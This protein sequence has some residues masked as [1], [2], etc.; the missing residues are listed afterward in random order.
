M[1]FLFFFSC[2]LLSFVQF[3]SIPQIHEIVCGSCVCVDTQEKKKRLFIIIGQ[4]T[5]NSRRRKKRSCSTFATTRL[6]LCVDSKMVGVDAIY[7]ITWRHRY[8]YWLRSCSC[9]CSFLLLCRFKKRN[10]RTTT[11]SA[12]TSGWRCD[13][14]QGEQEEQEDMKT[15]E[16]KII[17]S[18]HVLLRFLL[19]ASCISHCCSVYVYT[20][21]QIH[22][23]NDSALAYQWALVARDREFLIMGEKEN[24]IFWDV[25]A[26]FKIAKSILVAVVSFRLRRP[27]SG[28]RALLGIKSVV[29][30]PQAHRE[31]SL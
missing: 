17:I 12:A 7:I 27:F 22:L 1:L 6:C 25:L 15:A 28:V 21:G 14:R 9:C 2:A 31:S 23:T 5:S 3:I 4:S 26:G 13:V 18:R 19:A 29:H 11:R 20:F 24:L 30:P 8:L 16:Q 10:S